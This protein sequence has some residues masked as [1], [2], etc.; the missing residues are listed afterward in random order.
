MIYLL[1][2]ESS[3][4]ET[5]VAIL[6]ITNGYILSNIV[7]SQ[8]IIHKK[9]GGVI[10]ELASREHIF[11]IANITI[12][13]ILK[14]KISFNKIK[15]IAVT[16]KPGLIG[17]LIIGI[18]FA[19]GISKAL[20]IPLICINHIKAHLL[21][22][23]FEKG[24]PEKKNFIGLVASGG[25]SSLFI[26]K[27]KI[28]YKLSE[29]KDDAPG[30]TFDKI[31]N[32]LGLDYPAGNI[33]DKLANK[34][35]VSYFRFPI[36]LE[37]KTT[38]NYSFSGLKTSISI[39]IEKLKKRNIIFKNKILFNLAAGIR[40]SIISTLLKKAFLACKYNNVNT[41][42]IGGGVASNSLLRLMASIEGKKQNIYIFIPSPCLCTDN[43]IMIGKAAIH[44]LN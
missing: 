29:T 32:M 19:K 6:N 14:S 12:K 33:L 13:N 24:F 22:G 17:S 38:L 20:Q 25:H 26:Y 27:K 37:N 42:V 39:I 1:A 36:P 9:Y 21:A 3:C 11:H 5:A 15:L 44:T 4:D 43:A 30:E 8:I 23:L 40:Y 7:I 28:F 16:K 41:L 18:N 31:G 2:I 35:N 10:P 34:G